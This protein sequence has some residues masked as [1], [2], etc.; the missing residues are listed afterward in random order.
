MQE[1]GASTPVK[2]GQENFGCDTNGLSSS[3]ED[4]LNRSVVYVVLDCSQVIA[5][6]V[7]VT[8]SGQADS[9]PNDHII[10]RKNNHFHMSIDLLGM[11]M[12]HGSEHKNHLSHMLDKIY[13]I[14][15]FEL[16]ICWTHFN[17]GACMEND[18]A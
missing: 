3:I 16:R 9:Q 1:K 6:L 5:D 13:R 12:N 11:K 7:L 8:Q 18:W 14:E 17:F 4:C 10:L 15:Q 2:N